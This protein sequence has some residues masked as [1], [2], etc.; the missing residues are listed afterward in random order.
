MQ[1]HTLSAEKRDLVGRKVKKIRLLGKIPATIYGKDVPSVSITIDK[2][3]FKKIYAAAGGSGVVELSVDAENQSTGRHGRPVLIHHIQVHPVTDE[4]LHVE[5]YQVNLKE[6][7]HTKVPIE[8]TGEASAV[9]DKKG[10]VIQQLNEIEVEALP[11]DL[12]EK[13]EVDVASLS[14][15]GQEIRVK[16]LKKTDGVEVLTDPESMIVNVG[17]LISKEAEAAAVAEETEAE[18]VATT[19]GEAVAPSEEVSPTDK[20]EEKKVE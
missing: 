2:D 17:E 9:T 18:A 11:T 1:K 16:D 10:V 19:E 15:V 5:F 8:L 20:P 13:I 7:V 4:L 6:K 3:Q 12:P 14:E